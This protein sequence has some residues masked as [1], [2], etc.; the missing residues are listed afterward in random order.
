MTVVHWG[1]F[2]QPARSALAGHGYALQGVAGLARGL[3]Q[4]RENE[5]ADRLA[6]AQAEHLKALDEQAAANAQARQQAVQSAAEIDRAKI[7]QA[8]RARRQKLASDYLERYVG[9]ASSGRDA[10]AAIYKQEYER[11]AGRPLVVDGRPQPY[12]R[13]PA[14]RRLAADVPPDDPRGYVG[15]TNVT[16]Q[17]GDGDIAAD[18]AVATIDPWE[19]Q[20][21]KFAENVAGVFETATQG[22]TVSPQL[23]QQLQ[24]MAPQVLEAFGGDREKAM[25]WLQ[26]WWKGKIG[27]LRKRRALAKTAAGIRPAPAASATDAAI[28]A[29]LD[30]KQTLQHRKFARQ[31][32]LDIL[33]KY[34]VAENRK[35]IENL[36]QQIKVFQKRGP[37]W[38]A[39]QKQAIKQMIASVESGRVSDKDFRI[40][41]AGDGLW[42]Q[43]RDFWA[44]HG[45]VDEFLDQLDPKQ[46]E[47]LERA[48]RQSFSV[49]L[50]QYRDAYEEAKTHLE[51]LRQRQK[52]LA[53]VG[54]PEAK[55]RA[56]LIGEE[57]R[58]IEAMI[59]SRFPDGL[60]KGKGA[61]RA[62]APKEKSAPAS[63]PLTE[64][65]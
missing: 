20:R 45:N 36:A 57:V 28:A 38:A 3:V 9:A 13:A 14:P 43:L 15:P 52:E 19:A 49:R 46:L 11:L 35:S 1:T 50:R 17:R 6:Q 41:A 63:N 40:M 39:A 26:K 60:I 61:K 34:D 53:S 62:P 2:V 65:L 37:D 22:E 48:A 42:A 59:R 10:E 23:T 4:R 56:A 47:R 31:Q 33:N 29:G 18:L 16:P 8:E 27:L 55:K 58:Q 44:Q 25:D 21:R 51:E 24:T 30:P 7:E 64:G 12:Q 54:T 32:A 5:R